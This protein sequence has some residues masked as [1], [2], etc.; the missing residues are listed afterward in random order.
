MVR[1]QVCDCG[2]GR[3]LQPCGTFAAYKRHLKRGERP[4]GACAEANR[5]HCRSLVCTGCGKAISRGTGR[6]TQMCRDCAGWRSVPKPPPVSCPAPGCG[7]V[8]VPKRATGGRWTTFCS[9]QCAMVSRRN[10]PALGTTVVRDGKRYRTTDANR[11]KKTARRMGAGRGQE[12]YTLA[13]IAERD[14]FRCRAEVCLRGR[15]VVVMSGGNGSA[16]NKWGPTPDHILPL[17]LGGDD[18]RANVR[19]AHWACNVARGNRVLSAQ[20]LLIG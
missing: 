15:R 17:T 2:C 19:L 18:T 16:R 11:R 14:G 20:L 3:E 5:E 10:D 4:C 7:Q 8:F 1:V 6:R 9:F 13:E 12:P